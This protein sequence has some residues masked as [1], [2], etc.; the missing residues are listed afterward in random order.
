MGDF[1]HIV[2]SRVL[3]SACLFVNISCYNMFC[4]EVTPLPKSDGRA[5]EDGVLGG[6]SDHTEM[7]QSS[8][9]AKRQWEESTSERRKLGMKKAVIS[10]ST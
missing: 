1:E 5:T 7:R 8:R 3:K 9:A 6:K 10:V 2:W 4:V